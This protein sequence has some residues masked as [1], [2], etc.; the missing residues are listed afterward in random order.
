MVSKG[1]G[2]GI[3]YLG[4]VHGQQTPSSTWWNDAEKC[5]ED[6]DFAYA[7]FKL[8]GRWL[9]DGKLTGHPYEIVPGFL[10]GIERGLKMLKEE[11]VS[12]K[13]LIYQEGNTPPSF[14]HA[15]RALL[16]SQGRP[17]HGG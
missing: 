10:A 3:T 9:A 14:A 16:T 8:M 13:K 15:A 6:G 4:T 5:E 1:I 12:A 2:V 17:T 7:L 11:D